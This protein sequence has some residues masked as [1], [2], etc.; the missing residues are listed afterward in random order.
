[1]AHSESVFVPF[2]LPVPIFVS[3]AIVRVL[4]SDPVF[5]AFTRDT[6]D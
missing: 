4:G 6:Q 1:M 2:A 5:M 3:V